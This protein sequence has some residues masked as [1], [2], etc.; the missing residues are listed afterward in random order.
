MRVILSNET[1][2]I[3]IGKPSYLQCDHPPH[4]HQ[5]SLI[6]GILMA[7]AEVCRSTELFISSTNRNHFIQAPNLSWRF[8]HRHKVSSYT[9]V[10][11]IVIIRTYLHIYN[12]YISTTNRNINLVPYH[13]D[14]PHTGDLTSFLT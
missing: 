2:M 9:H 7:T 5:R 14:S 6:D 4:H 8:H 11:I 3:F 13:Q 10:S 12:I 1:Q